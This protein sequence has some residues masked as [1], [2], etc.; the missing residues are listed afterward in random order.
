MSTTK[1]NRAA[2]I[3]RRSFAAVIALIVLAAAG[4]SQLRAEEILVA[5]SDASHQET[6]AEKAAL[7]TAISNSA[8]QANE[9]L[10]EEVRLELAD[11]V[12]SK[13]RLARVRTSA[14]G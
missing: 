11:R 9:A 4:T 7:D 3:P 12:R 5:Y 10:T 8:E 14:R 13:V 1:T 2:D 6:R